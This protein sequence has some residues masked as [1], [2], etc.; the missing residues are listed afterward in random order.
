MIKNFENWLAEAYN[1]INQKFESSDSKVKDLVEETFLTNDLVIIEEDEGDFTKLTQ[2][3]SSEKGEEILNTTD[4]RLTLFTSPFEFIN[5]ET[6]GS[7]D[8]PI[9]SVFIVKKE[10]L[11]K[12]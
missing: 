11:D 12:L 4:D 5:W 1:W 2:M 9:E 8:E 6:I 7:D 3:M 10:D